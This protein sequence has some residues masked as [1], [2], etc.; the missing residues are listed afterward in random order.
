MKEGELPVNL[1]KR[2]KNF[3]VQFPELGMRVTARKGLCSEP[4]AAAPRR[5][6]EAGGERPGRQS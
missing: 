2:F 5:P 6:E 4:R 1:F 3:S